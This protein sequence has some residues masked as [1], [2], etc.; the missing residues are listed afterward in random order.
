MSI[1]YHLG[2]ANMVADDISRI[3]M[4]SLSQVEEA[5]KDLVKYVL[6]WKIL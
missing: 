4:G 1:L 6:G 5:N 3:T 2:K